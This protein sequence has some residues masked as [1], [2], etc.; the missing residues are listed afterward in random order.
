MADL[1]E[2][3][4]E[5]V[6]LYATDQPDVAVI[7]R[8]EPDF[9]TVSLAAS[10]RP[11][12]PYLQRRFSAA[13]TREIRLYM[14]RRDDRISIRGNGGGGIKI[15]VIGG[16]GDDVFQVEDSRS[17]LYLYD[18]EGQN[19]VAGS[20]AGGLDTRNF[21]EWVWSEEDRDQPRDWGGR[22]LPIFAS[23]YSSDLGV[24]IG[25]G[26]RLERYGF[27]KTPFSSGF[28]I[29][30][31][32][33]VTKVTGR[34]AIAGRF[35]RANSPVFTTFQ[36]RYS[37]LDVLDFYGFGN[38][39]PS[40][41]SRFH[42]VDHERA[43]VEAAL[44]VSG[45][46]GLEL[47]L[48]VLASRSSTSESSGG[49]FRG[50]RDN[51]YGAVD[52]WQLGATAGVVYDPPVDP[53]ESANLFHLEIRGATFPEVLDVVTPFTTAGGGISAVL[54][55]SVS[56]PISLALRVGGEKIWGDA[57]PW[58]E[59][60]FLGGARTVRG[61]DQERFAGDASLFGSGELRLRLG[62]ARVLVPV[63]IGVFGFADAG[64][65]YLDG[66]S[67]GGWHTGLG[68]GIWLTPIT[69]QYMLRAGFGVSD[70][71]T[72][73]YVATGLPLLSIF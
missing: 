6:D 53:N 14:K 56:S 46:S 54:A 23:L 59:A 42:E 68:G 72:K 63:D 44:G 67:D 19:A 69:Q 49:F 45:D 25:T 20:S 7:D 51:L 47:T 18:S 64:R 26:V 58:S 16:R 71:G 27:R 10:E 29:T 3:L 55:P 8:T 24:V 31:A 37:G 36:V 9:V 52:F 13:E 57:F 61:F 40:G 15:R 38:D 12:A 34:G 11:N 73:I 33:S 41:R 62:K 70:E 65:V 22:T 17:G 48:G 21:E 50:L 43:S 28:D 5:A 2:L 4:A 60:T 32:F 30:G 35:N 39:T 66:V 1:Y